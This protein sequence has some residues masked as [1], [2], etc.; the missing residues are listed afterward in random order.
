M[1]SF[2]QKR[3]FQTSFIKFAPASENIYSISLLNLNLNMLICKIIPRTADVDD[4]VRVAH[5]NLRQRSIWIYAIL[6]NQTVYS[7]WQI[8]FTRA[9]GSSSIMTI[10][11]SN[12]TENNVS[13]MWALILN[14]HRW[15]KWVKEGP[16]DTLWNIIRKNESI[17]SLY[18]SPRDN[19]CHFEW[20][21]GSL[22]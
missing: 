1:K 8:I 11:N 15:F 3:D 14:R 19:D 17:G 12:V 9:V 7:H 13:I 21:N 5:I 22:G 2:E 6:R 16:W 4:Q 18:Q 10:I 20:D